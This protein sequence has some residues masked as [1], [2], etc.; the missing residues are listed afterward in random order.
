V[1]ARLENDEET[2]NAEESLSRYEHEKTRYQ[3]AKDLHERKLINQQEF[4]FVSYEKLALTLMP[5]ISYPPR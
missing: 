3:R 5:D 1:L 2:V 4:G